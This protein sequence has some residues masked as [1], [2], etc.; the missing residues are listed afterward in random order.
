VNKVTIKSATRRDHS[1]TGSNEIKKCIWRHNAEDMEQMKRMG[2]AGRKCL[3][4][5]LV[6][7]VIH[8]EVKYYWYMQKKG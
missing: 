2:K 7:V 6:H 1:I 4:N 5:M 3:T 8:S